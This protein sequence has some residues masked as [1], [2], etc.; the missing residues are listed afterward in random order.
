[1]LVWTDLVQSTKEEAIFAF[2][3]FSAPVR[4]PLRFWWIWVGGAIAGTICGFYYDW[5]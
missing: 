4:H 2:K 1:M 3:A 5:K